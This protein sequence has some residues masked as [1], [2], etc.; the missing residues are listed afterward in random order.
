VLAAPYRT[1]LRTD[2]WVT[3][4]SFAGLG[5]MAAGVVVTAEKALDIVLPVLGGAVG[6]V[7]TWLYARYKRRR[8][9]AKPVS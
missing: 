4:L 5:L 8:W 7:G 3:G 6:G 1:Y 9:S 2:R